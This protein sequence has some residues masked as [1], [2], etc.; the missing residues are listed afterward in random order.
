MNRRS[1]IES[2]RRELENLAIASRNIERAIRDLK[3]QEQQQPLD[4]AAPAVV[5]GPLDRDGNEIRVGKM[6]GFLR[7]GSL[8]PR[9]ELL[10]VSPRTIFVFLLSATTERKF[11]ELP[12]T[13]ESFKSNQ[14][15]YSRYSSKQ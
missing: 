12:E 1:T 6:S 8:K 3:D 10:R 4:Q 11:Q 15:V 5:V 13:S 9:K 7:K 2:L 14:H